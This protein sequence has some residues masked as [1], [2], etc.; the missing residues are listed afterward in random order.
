MSRCSVI[1]SIVVSIAVTAVLQFFWY[2][3]YE[4]EK[5]KRS[6]WRTVW[7]TTSHIKPFRF[8]GI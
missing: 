7:Y 4:N 8:S 2:V 6:E 1:A 3:V 5:K